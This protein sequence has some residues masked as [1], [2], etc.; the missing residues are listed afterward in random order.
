MSK[1][2]KA[3]DTVS[4]HYTGRMESGE[5]F[6]SSAGR[7]PLTF[8]VGS[9]QL[10]R[11]F[12]DA[13]VG[14]KV[15]EKKTVNIPPADGYGERRD[16]LFVDLPRTHIPEGMDLQVG[17]MV[18]LVDSSRNTVPA[19]VAEVRDAFVRMDLNHFLAGKILVF[20]IE[21]LEIS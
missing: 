13:V 8:T 4:V 19:V 11:G 14:M 17:S 3:G 21:M 16:D 5:V 10:I 2:V 7:Q 20:D 9:G 1:E 18:E 15:G 12:D 6:D